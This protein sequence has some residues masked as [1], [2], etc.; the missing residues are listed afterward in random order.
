MVAKV[1]VQGAI[2]GGNRIWTM[3]GKMYEKVVAKVDDFARKTANLGSVTILRRRQ[4]PRSTG[5][6]RSVDG[7]MAQKMV[8][9]VDAERVI[10]GVNGIA[11]VAEKVDGKV[12]AG[13][14]EMFENLAILARQPESELRDARM[15]RNFDHKVDSGVEEKVDA[16]ME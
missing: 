12:D 5:K 3:V 4:L 11:P 2:P 7:K 13:M 15:R 8:T 10:P 16:K 1:E 14:G 6:T 9:K